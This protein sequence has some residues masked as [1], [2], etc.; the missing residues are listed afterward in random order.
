MNSNNIS[1]GLQLCNSIISGTQFKDLVGEFKKKNCRSAT[2]ELGRGYWRGF[3]KRNKHL[4]SSKKGV[5]FDT[6]R[7]EWCTYLNME[8]MYNEVY[9]SLVDSGLAVK[10]DTPSWRNDAGE[11]VNEENA[12]G[13]ESEFELIHPNWLIFVDEVGSNTS[14]AKDGNVGGE[15]FLCSKQGRPQQRAATKDTHLTVLGFTS[16]AGDPVMCAIIFA[17]KTMRDEWRLGFDPLTEWIREENDIHC[18]IG[19]GKVYPL[20]PNC[21]FNG[22]NV[23]YFCCCSESGSITG[24]LLVEMLK[25]MDSLKLFDHTTGLNPFLLLDGHGSH[26][27]LEFLEYI[28]AAE[29]KWHCCIGLPYGTSYWQVGD[30]SE[31]NGC[32]KIAL[33]KAKQQLVLKKN[34][35]GLEYTINKE[36]IVGLVRK[37]WKSSFEKVETNCQAIS[38]RG[39]GPRALNYN[40]LCHPEVLTTKPGCMK[41]TDVSTFDINICPDELNLS[42]G[43]AGTLV[44]KI[45]VY[46]TK[47][48]DNSGTNAVE[49]MRKRKATAEQHIQSHDKRITAGLLAAAGRFQLGEEIRNYIQERANEKE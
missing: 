2:S 17:A 27:E 24:T 46:K 22:K 31:Q 19:E 7:A 32:F 29:H 44:D 16:A 14:Q 30:S 25:A 26:F 33:S 3:L 47:E 48:A 1:Q 12:V 39:W 4:I 11:V 28:N 42:E 6:K 49:R 23:P 34:D 20:G 45:F 18:N 38:R 9:T 10:H 37:A 15:K 35:N 41:N 8:E 36:D 40:A 21:T 43:L 13:C 5:K